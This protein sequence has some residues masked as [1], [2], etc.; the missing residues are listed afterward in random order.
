M[1]VATLLVAGCGDDAPRLRALAPD[2]VVL[3]FGD[4]LTYGTGAA[5]EESYPARLAARIGREVGHGGVAG[6]GRGEGLRRLPAVLDEVR[7]ALVVL[8]HGGNDFLRRLDRAATENNLK[9]MVETIRASGAEV[10]LLGVPRF[11]LLLSADELYARVAEALAV[12]LEAD[13]IPDLLGDNDF[14]SDTV[15][16]NAA[17]YAR[18]AAAIEGLLRESGAL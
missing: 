14:K 9:R 7:P 17:G 3:A 2:A 11:G 16:P 6:G 4:S 8:C 1:L 13:I 12:P 15:H 5:P 10:V 18:M